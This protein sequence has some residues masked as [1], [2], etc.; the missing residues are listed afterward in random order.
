M[1]GT[2]R[3]RWRTDFPEIYLTLLGGR[4]IAAH[5]FHYDV[6]ERRGKRMSSLVSGTLSEGQDR[7]LRL[8]NSLTAGDWDGSGEVLTED[9]E[10][11][12]CR[13][14]RRADDGSR[15]AVLTV[16]P[17]HHHPSRSTPARHI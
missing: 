3:A 14:W 13:A 15:R 2:G 5:E 1:C 9:S 12:F 17:R 4:F 7:S 10:R 6:V 16:L 8:S 11:A